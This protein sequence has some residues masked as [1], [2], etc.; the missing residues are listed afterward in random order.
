M[1]RKKNNTGNNI[2]QKLLLGT[3]VVVWMLLIVL[4]LVFVLFLVKKSSDGPVKKEEWEEI[5]SEEESEEESIEET[6][7]VETEEE[8]SEEEST[9]ETV[10]IDYPAPEYQ[11]K[12]D[13]VTIEVPGLTQ[14]YTL[15]WV[16][17]LHLT[18][19]F[20]PAEDVMAEHIETIKLRH[21]AL[22]INPNVE[23]GTVTYSEEL[24][25]EIIKYLNYTQ[26]DGKRFDGIIFGG[27]I[28][29]YCSK[30]NLNLFLEEYQKLD[31]SIPFLYIRADHDYGFWYGGEALTEPMAEALHQDIAGGDDLSQKYLDFGEFVVIGINR[32]N[33][34]MSQAQYDII[35]SQYDK[36]KEENKP[37]IAVTH[38]PYESED[39]AF[40]EFSM[41]VKNKV[42]YWTYFS[43][44]GNNIPNVI[45]R[46]YLDEIY[47]PDTQVVKVLSG[48][49]HAGWDGMITQQVSQHVFNPAYLGYIGIIH[50]VPASE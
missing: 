5:H 26:I 36:A 7:V 33:K 30:S 4:L 22:F 47:A 31:H 16:S 41:Q 19:D 37:I 15:A 28:M 23:T 8:S 20:E 18:S 46:Q 2:G 44:E 3:G 13:E 17:D 40:R 12:A 42:Y 38:V 14:S 9:T 6:T 27:D 10:V 35:K 50:V 43:E 1:K 11:F 21:D 34:D 48:H 24:W 25:P 39:G 49:M 32:S 29:D 45:T